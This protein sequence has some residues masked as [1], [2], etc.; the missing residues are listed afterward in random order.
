MKEQNII[1]L[2]GYMLIL[3]KFTYHSTMILTHKND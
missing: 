3:D 2:L 1:L